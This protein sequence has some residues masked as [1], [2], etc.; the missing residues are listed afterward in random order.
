MQDDVIAR[1]E[2]RYEEAHA[3][4]Q[5]LQEQLAEAMEQL[6]NARGRVA[7]LIQARGKL[8]KQLDAQHAQFS[9]ER[10]ALATQTAALKVR[11]ALYCTRIDTQRSGNPAG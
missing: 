2:A 9:A 6:D 4:Q 3:E 10:T 1:F 11:N 5:A 7:D 8:R